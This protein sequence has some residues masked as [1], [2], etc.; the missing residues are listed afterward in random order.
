[1]NLGQTKKKVI[2]KLKHAKRIVDALRSF[3][4][5]NLLDSSMDP[6]HAGFMKALF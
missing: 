2:K 6:L 3:I 4:R 5:E 1:M